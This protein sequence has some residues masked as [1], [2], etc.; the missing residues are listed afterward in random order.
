M[1]PPPEADV[2]P[3]AP[4][5]QD[6][7]VSVVVTVTAGFIVTTA[8]EVDVFPPLSLI[9]TVYILVAPGHGLIF[10]VVAPLLHEYVYGEV[11][12]VPLAVTV[13]HEPG[14]AELPVAVTLGPLQFIM[15]IFF[16]IVLLH[17]PLLTE[18]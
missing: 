15:V 3:F 4:P 16:V 12:P 10:C 5:L 11:P 7:L 6:M 2:E 14:Q 8:V 1:P 9:V 13:A 17:V 18:C